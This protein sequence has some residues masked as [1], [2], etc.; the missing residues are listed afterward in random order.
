MSHDRLIEFNKAFLNLESHR[1]TNTSSNER[2]FNVQFTHEIKYAN[3]S[4]FHMPNLHSC[5]KNMRQLLIWAHQVTMICLQILFY[6]TIYLLIGD[7]KK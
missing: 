4:N 3:Q 1:T 2:Y 6:D 5:C 7:T